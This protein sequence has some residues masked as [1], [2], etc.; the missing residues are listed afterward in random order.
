MT[1]ESGDAMSFLAIAFSRPVVLRAL[2]MASVVGV[3]LIAINHG[4]ALARG[5]WSTERMIQMAVTFLV[6][7]GVSTV[8]SAAALRER[9]RQS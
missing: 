9:E 8:S 3:L 7:Y 4:A 6:P 1:T 2:K 5:E